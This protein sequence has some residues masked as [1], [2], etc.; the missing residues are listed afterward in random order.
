MPDLALAGVVDKK[1]SVVLVAVAAALV[2]AAPA[3]AGPLLSGKLGA[4]RALDRSCDA[5]LG[6]ARGSS[7]HKQVTAPGSGWINARLT[8]ASGRRADWDVAVFDRASRRVVAA[9]ADF[10]SNDVAS[11]LVTKGE[12]LVVQACRRSGASKV[13]LDVDFNAVSTRKAP[14]ASMVRVSTPNRARRQELAGLGVD[15]T[16]HVGPGFTDVVI[17]GAG[18]ARKLRGRKF[19]YRTLVSDLAARDRAD[20][21]ADAHFAATTRASTFPSRRTTYRR[22]ADYGDDMKKLVRENPT[23][24][25]PVTL[26]YKTWEGRTLQGIEIG[27]NVHARDGRPVFLMLGLHHAREWPAGEHTIEWAYELINGWRAG[28]ARVRRI[29]RAERTIVIP[30]VNPDGFN[31]SR[32]AGQ[33]E[34]GGNGRGGNDTVETANIVAHVNEY[35]RK[36]CRLI[37]DSPSGNCAQP[38]FGLAEPGVDINRNYGALWGGPG[39]ST[40]PTAQDYR[41]PAPFSEPESRDV[42]WLISRRQVTTMITNHTDAGLVLRP[43]GVSAQGLTIDEAAMKKLGDAMAAQNGYKSQFGFQLYDTSGTTEDWSYLSTG[44]YGYTFEIGQTNFHPPFA[45]AAAEWDGTAELARKVHGHGNREAYFIAAENVANRTQHSLLT[46]KAPDGAVLRL[47]KT[48][49]TPTSPVIDANG[50]EGAVRTFTDNLDSTMVVPSSGRFTW[51]INPSTRPLVAKAKGRLA[52]GKPSAAINFAS[53]GPA[54]TTPCAASDSPPPSCYEDHLITVP[55]GA[56]IDNARATVRIQWNTPVSDWDMLIYRADAAGHATGE[57]IGSSQQGTTN[58]EE[59]TINEPFLPNRFVVRAVN[60]AAVAPADSWTGRVTFGGPPAY[61]PARTEDWTLTCEGRGKVGL[62]REILI[63]RG[64]SRTLDLSKCAPV[65]CVSAH[66][67]IKGKRV[68]PAVL[69]RSRKRQRKLIKS[70]RLKGR[71][72]IDRYCVAGGGSLR[73]AYPTHRLTRRWSRRTRK[74]YKSKAILA[75]SSSKRFKVKKVG[76]GT[77]SRT[78]RRRLH[79]ERRIKV[80]TSVW[81]VVSG[82][83]SRIL[84]RIHKGKV[85]DIGLASKRLTRTRLAT[86]RLLHGWG[87]RP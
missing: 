1:R 87:R 70:R 22:L 2:A 12:S 37:D 15:V 61:T 8:P 31:A 75:I 85:A 18:D 54:A 32:E 56:G 19:V 55:R 16:E 84:F 67:G 34:G 38:S 66:K 36:N 5:Q 78:A 21:R 48:F 82:K 33:N 40:D 59:T 44:G 57:P 83:Q 68:G 71:A 74:R 80:G 41:G 62:R 76:V 42:R 13:D 46:G 24:V 86:S 50:N 43:P 28:N 49:K 60:F 52:H 11:G 4:R 47:H 10:G 26:P 29:M 45:T 72:K 27:S 9:S 51:D 77:R 3:Q 69:G 58:F 25:R 23:L 39:A 73:I 35:R 53:N 65:A 7:V 20:R 79:G 30:V 17:Q 14:K 81:Y 64:Q 63:K 6:A